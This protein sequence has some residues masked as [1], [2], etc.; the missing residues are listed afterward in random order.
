MVVTAQTGRRASIADFLCRNQRM[1]SLSAVLSS[2][3]DNHLAWMKAE[4]LLSTKTLS[5]GRSSKSFSQHP[6]Y[7]LSMN[8]TD[9]ITWYSSLKFIL[10]VRACI[11]IFVP[12]SYAQVL[13][14][15]CEHGKAARWCRG[16]VCAREVCPTLKKARARHPRLL[17]K[18]LA[19]VS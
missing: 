16:A 14:T 7:A 4:P 19:F 5:S 1:D 3:K 11:G 2:F 13:Y 9:G 15:C 17:S 8:R 18:Q 6:K 10:F 12:V